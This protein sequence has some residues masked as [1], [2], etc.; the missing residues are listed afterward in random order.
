M[1]RVRRTIRTLRWLGRWAP[2]EFSHEKSYTARPEQPRRIRYP[3]V[4]GPAQRRAANL[5]EPSPVSELISGLS[6]LIV[7]RR[8]EGAGALRVGRH[9]GF[10]A[11]RE[12][13][14]AGCKLPVLAGN[15]R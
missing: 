5:D 14:A 7:Q 12:S 6:D 13:A 2:G 3:L 15:R 10:S 4:K 11:F 9:Q 8:D 1:T